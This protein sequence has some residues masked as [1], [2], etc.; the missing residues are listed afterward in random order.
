MDG[1]DVADYATRK[2]NHRLAGSFEPRPIG[3]NHPRRIDLAW[4]KTHAEQ[5]SG[6]FAS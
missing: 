3:G 5:F 2:R 4:L 6:R 1:S